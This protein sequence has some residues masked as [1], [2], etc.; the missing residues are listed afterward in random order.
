MGPLTVLFTCVTRRVILSKTKTPFHA[1]NE[2]KLRTVQE[3]IGSKSPV[4]ELQMSMITLLQQSKGQKLFGFT[5][6]SVWSILAPLP[7]ALLPGSGW[8]S[9]GQVH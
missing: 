4:L 2:R 8:P 1:Q 9:P 6:R 5:Q 7:P 3:F